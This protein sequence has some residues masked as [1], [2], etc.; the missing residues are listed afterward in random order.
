MCG[1][2]IMA[3]VLLLSLTA[4]DSLATVQHAS[5]T[6]PRRVPFTPRMAASTPTPPWQAA[7]EPSPTAPDQKPA[8]TSKATQD[9]SAQPQS[10]EPVATDVAAKPAAKPDSADTDRNEGPDPLAIKFAEILAQQRAQAA[11]GAA[12]A[13]TLQ[14]PPKKEVPKEL[15]PEP[16]PEPKETG[17]EPPTIE[18]LLLRNPDDLVAVPRTERVR[19]LILSGD[20]FSN[21]SLRGLDGLNVSELSIEA[22]HISNAGLQYVGSVKGLRCLRLW[23]PG[24]DDDAL[25]HVAE[26]PALE[27]LDVE[28]TAIEGTG[29]EKLK[30]LQK[31]DMLVLGSQMSDSQ[32]ASLKHLPALRQLDLR[33]CSRLTLAC[34]EPLAQL[35]DLKTVWLPGHIRTKGKRVLK[36]SL[37]TCEVRW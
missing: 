4:A 14:E 6:A 3:V 17:D 27:I 28:G 25:V 10:E 2:A 35:A 29:L 13:K 24:V 32:I 16:V 22:T 8:A 36:E 15:A 30:G 31:L 7:R 21:W 37:P 5:N 12:A 20:N 34:L 9:P 33:A 23:T 11:A 19:R 26:S 18:V 1:I